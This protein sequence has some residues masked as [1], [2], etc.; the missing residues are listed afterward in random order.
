MGIPSFC[1]FTSSQEL[2]SNGGPSV[3]GFPDNPRA[4]ATRTLLLVCKETHIVHPPGFHPAGNF[5][6]LCKLP[7]KCDPLPR[8]ERPWRTHDC[9][10]RLSFSNKYY[11]TNTL[12]KAKW[13]MKGLL[14]CKWRGQPTKK[15]KL[16]GLS[17]RANY[18]D[19]ATAA[20]RRNDCHRLWTEAD[21]WSAWRIPTAVFSVSLTGA[22]TFLS[23]SS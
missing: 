10:P 12:R 9:E 20:Y 13:C 11:I 23:S 19:R 21:T 7:W 6:L 22:A 2:A 15:K 4:R 14:R 18:T 1:P 17:P 3:P 8:I 16:H 5:T